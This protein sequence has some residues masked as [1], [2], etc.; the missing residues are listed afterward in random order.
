LKHGWKPPTTLTESEYNAL[1]KQSPSAL[2]GF[3]GFGCSHSGKFFGGYAR[4]NTGR[5]YAK[6][7]HNSL[8]KLRPA[9]IDTQLILGTYDRVKVS[10]DVIYCDPPYANTTGF[11]TGKF[12]HEK[13]WQWVR[14][15]SE[16]SIVL[17]S[18]YNAPTDFLPVWQA[19]VRTDMRGANQDRVEKL[20]LHESLTH[21][22]NPVYYK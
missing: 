3:A 18:E 20:F 15:R 8:N 9:L 14:D 17:V 10:A 11:S 19:K 22:V 7:A 4:D 16:R 2:R 21:A 6:N 13:F 5:N 1:K 12:D